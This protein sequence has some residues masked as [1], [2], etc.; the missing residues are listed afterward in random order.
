MRHHQP[1]SPILCFEKR[2]ALCWHQLWCREEGVAMQVACLYLFV[3]LPNCWFAHQRIH[4]KEHTQRHKIQWKAQKK[5]FC[6]AFNSILYS[7]FSGLLHCGILDWRIVPAGQDRLPGNI[8]VI[9][10][11]DYP[12]HPVKGHSDFTLCHP[13]MEEEWLGGLCD[14]RNP[15]WPFKDFSFSFFQSLSPLLVLFFLP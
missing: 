2:P 10:K 4:Q 3:C 7:S 5:I 1:Q 6:L 11:N 15:G 14:G 9:I 8:R 12:V 13:R